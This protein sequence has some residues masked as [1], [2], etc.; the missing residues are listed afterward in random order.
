MISVGDGIVLASGLDDVASSELVVIQ[1]SMYG[2]AL[3]LQNENAGIILFGSDRLIGVGDIVSRTEKIIGIRVGT[4]GY[5]GRIVDS[6][7]NFIDGLSSQVFPEGASIDIKAL[8]NVAQES[9]R[10]SLFTGIKAVDSM[11]PYWERTKRAY[12]RR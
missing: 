10:Q 11:I 12:Y 3:N 7:G 2:L 1:D 9:V 8:G 6:L 5:L 4:D